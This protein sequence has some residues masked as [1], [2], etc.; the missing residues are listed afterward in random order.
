MDIQEDLEI[1]K[2]DYF[3]TYHKRYDKRYD[4]KNTIGIRTTFNN[5][6]DVLTKLNMIKYLIKTNHNNKCSFKDKV[7]NIREIIIDFMIEV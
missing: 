7:N 6:T 1:S 2:K 3:I 4:N 5:K